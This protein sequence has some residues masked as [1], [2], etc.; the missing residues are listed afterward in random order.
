MRGCVLALILQKRPLS[1]WHDFLSEIRSETSK[2]LGKNETRQ[3]QR[4]WRRLGNCMVQIYLAIM[5]TFPGKPSKWCNLMADQDGMCNMYVE[6][7]VKY[8]Y[9]D[10]EDSFKT[11]RY[12]Q[13]T[14]KSI[15][16]D[17]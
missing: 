3:T 15:L 17:T 10:T 1:D 5:K 12:I 14:F 8:V 9:S 6:P 2:R 4:R 13:C 11:P 7:L 16:V